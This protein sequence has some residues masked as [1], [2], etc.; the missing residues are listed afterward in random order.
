MSEKFE[1]RFKMARMSPLKMGLSHWVASGEIGVKL[2]DDEIDAIQNYSGVAYGLVNRVLY[3]R[4]K[5]D[6]LTEY[7]CEEVEEIIDLLDQIFERVPEK[8]LAVY[9]G[10]PAV[11][12]LFRGTS[13]AEWVQENLVKGKEVE[14]AGFLSTSSSVS[15]AVE[16]RGGK[17]GLLYKILAKKGLP[18]SSIS[19]S[20]EEREVILPRGSRFLVAGVKE[21]RMGG[22]VVK[23]EQV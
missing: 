22:V 23:L 3:G 13:V 14:L 21:S 10:V 18:I 9:R 19:C 20:P 8:R 12:E 6:R 15:V 11:E 7:A 17:G 1:Y 2:T 5:L 4:T 16:F